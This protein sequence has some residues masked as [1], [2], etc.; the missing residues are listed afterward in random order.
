MFPL[1][2]KK[3]G[4]RNH[5]ADVALKIQL[6][7]HPEPPRLLKDLVK[8]KTSQSTHFLQHIRKYNSAFQ[9]T[10][11]A[12]NV[13]TEGGFMPTFKV[14]GQVYYRFGSLQPLPGNEPKHIQI[15]FISDSNKHRID[16]ITTKELD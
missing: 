9:M 15:Y 16:V 1:L 10:Y 13:I 12:A 8:G 7:I 11:F 4:K 6:S 2:C 5:R 3:N 14:Q